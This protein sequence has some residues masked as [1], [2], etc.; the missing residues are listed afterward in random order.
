[1]KGDTLG[2][3]DLLLQEGQEATG[4]L[5]PAQGLQ[6]VLTGV[7]DI[8][9]TITKK[10]DTDTIGQDQDQAHTEDTEIE[11]VTPDRLADD[12]YTSPTQLII[13]PKINPQPPQL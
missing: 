8:T 1:M 3:R 9:D 6:A 10:E 11:T 4:I 2:R 12:M 7:T 13:S 5:I